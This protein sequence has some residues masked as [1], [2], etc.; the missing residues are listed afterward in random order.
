MCLRNSLS[1]LLGDF[2]VRDSLS[3]EFLFHFLFSLFHW[4]TMFKLDDPK[5]STSEVVSMTAVLS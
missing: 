3:Q 2:E 5:F 1:E 4:K